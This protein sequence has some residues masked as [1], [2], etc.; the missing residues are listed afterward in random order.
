MSKH[1]RLR[2][3]GIEEPRYLLKHY[4]EWA[5]P[6]FQ[7]DSL[8]LTVCLMRARNPYGLIKAKFDF[9]D[10]KLFQR[11]PER[12]IRFPVLALQE[13]FLHCHAVVAKVSSDYQSL[14]M[15]SLVDIVMHEFKKTLPRTGDVHVA[16]I[17]GGAGIPLIYALERQGSVE[18]LPEA[19]HLPCR[20]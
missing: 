4:R 8:F 17:A 7:G 6:H 5:E 18:V 19:M 1:F 12:L 3:K 20:S 9:I 16:P 10:R 14:E 15:D 11:R 2:T 13:G